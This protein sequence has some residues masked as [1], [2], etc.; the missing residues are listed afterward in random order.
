MLGDQLLKRALTDGETGLA[1]RISLRLE[2]ERAIARAERYGF[3]LGLV[4]V[5][6][7]AADAEAARELF[8]H[9]AGGVRR[10]DCLARTG[11][12]EVTLLL[13]H[14]DAD[15]APR[16]VDRLTR[17]C[18]EFRAVPRWASVETRVQSEVETADVRRLLDRI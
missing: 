3:P 5:C 17:M 1:N 16:V 18:D 6:C 4:R 12:R 2:L 14:D 7:G 15:E 13:S 8:R 9:L 10:A 11:D